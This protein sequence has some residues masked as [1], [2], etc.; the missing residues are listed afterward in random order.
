[1]ND[2][3]GREDALN[4]FWNALIG[5][6]R[7]AAETD[8]TAEEIEVV[9]RLRSAATAPLAGL[10][11]DAAW[12]RVLS[13]IEANRS[14]KEGLMP[15]TN[16]VSVSTPI[17]LPNGRAAGHA[18]PAR[19]FAPAHGTVRWSWGH[20]ATVALLML[21]VAAGLVAFGPWRPG[22]TPPPG[23]LPLAVVTSA[24]PPVAQEAATPAASPEAGPALAEFMGEISLDADGTS[25]DLDETDYSSAAAGVA[26]ADDGTLYVIDSLQDQIRV[27]DRDGTR[28]ATWGEGG[29]GPGQYRFEQYG[30]SWGDLAIGPDGNIYVLDPFNSR[31]Q[32]LG[33][34]GIFLRQWG[35]PGSAEGQLDDP[36]GIG[37]DD[38]GRVYV[39]EMGN[40]RL[41]IFDSEGQFLD[42]WTPTADEGGP[43]QSP[44]DVSIDAAGTVSVTE[45][46][47]NQVV[48]FDAK[49]AVIDRLG[50]EI[51]Q[52]GALKRPWG[53]ALDGQDNLYVANG[54]Q[55]Q[56]FAADGSPRGVIAG[57]AS[58][59]DQF[60]R[61]LHVTVS[62]DGLLY[63][64]DEPNRR[65]Q[66]FRLLP[67]LV[68][69]PATLVLR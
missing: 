30:Y 17:M 6:E 13:R 65:V 11:A 8:L 64:S 62:S 49:G 41:Q 19:G 3:H 40:R 33:P 10:S 38:A 37:I 31:I 14:A 29:E 53:A 59:P 22:S 45:F 7:D 32:V 67:P 15:L 43:L 34:D 18:S 69:T 52:P 68:S 58:E 48:R 1:M 47:G 20:F 44:A 60:M 21:T 35:E 57:V 16:A 46:D 55:V 39:A 23:D 56:V 25:L 9:H 26:V 50:G 66:V 51:G 2:Q 54:P 61:L 63:V 42:I 5:A 27:F 36:S 12:P 4:Q 28:V 24:I